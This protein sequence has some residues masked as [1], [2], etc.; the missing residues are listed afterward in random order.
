MS[1]GTTG[2]RP[3]RIPRARRWRDGSKMV[4]TATTVSRRDRHD[5]H[6]PT[7]PP[8]RRP[9]PPPAF[10]KGSPRSATCGL[11]LRRGRDGPSGAAARLPGVLVRLAHI[12]WA[13]RARPASASLHRTCAATTSRRSRDGCGNYTA[14]TRRRRPRP[15]PRLGAESTVSA[16]T[17]RTAAWAWPRTTRTRSSASRSSTRPHP[18]RPNEDCTTC[19][20]IA[21]WVLLLQLPGLPER[22]VGISRRFFNASCATPARRSRRR[23]SPLQRCLVSPS[24]KAI[25]DYYRAPFVYPPRMPSCPW[26]RRRRWSSGANATA[27]SAQTRRPPIAA[28]S[29]STASSA[30][31]RVALGPRARPCAST[32]C[33]STSPHPPGS[34]PWRPPVIRQ[35]R[36]PESPRAAAGNSPAAASACRSTPRRIFHLQGRRGC[37]DGTRTRGRRDHNPEPL[38][39]RPPGSEPGA[40]HCRRPITRASESSDH[41]LEPNSAPGPHRVPSN[42]DPG[43]A[44]SQPHRGGRM[45]P[46]AGLFCDRGDRI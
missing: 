11:A 10:A 41:A 33:S 39:L 35:H 40:T 6:E 18:R 14:A 22:R 38:N 30:S 17:G 20:A 3:G 1:T 37:S 31:R 43:L 19:V 4:V 44:P 29:T 13:A 42:L 25:V 15:H 27:T 5:R 2:W 12:R 36:L 28:C 7:H 8:A 21:P 9:T 34:H 24:A 16:T 32:S 45:Q 46:L 23:S 26:S